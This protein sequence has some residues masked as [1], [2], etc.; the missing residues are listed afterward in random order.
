MR[1]STPEG[2][3]A[4]RTGRSGMKARS[5][6][7]AQLLRACTA[8]FL[9][10]FFSRFAG[11]GTRVRSAIR[12]QHTRRRGCAMPGEAN[13]LNMVASTLTAKLSLQVVG[14]PRRATRRAASSACRHAE[15]N[16]A[17]PARALGQQVV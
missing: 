4:L 13:L 11:A 10:R 5:E 7:P 15:K 12:A 9:R 6:P 16:P 14:Q 17:T 3:A 2:R 1:R 8:V